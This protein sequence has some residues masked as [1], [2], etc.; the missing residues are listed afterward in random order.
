M[1]NVREIRMDGTTPATEFE[2][3]AST[4]P[5]DAEVTSGGSSPKSSAITV[6]DRYGAAGAAAALAAF[7]AEHPDIVRYENRSRWHLECV[8]P[9]ATPRPGRRFLKNW[10]RDPA[11]E[12]SDGWLSNIAADGNNLM[13][14]LEWEPRYCATPRRHFPCPSCAAGLAERY[15]RYGGFYSCPACEF[16]TN[17]GT[18]KAAAIE[19]AA[20]ITGWCGTLLEVRYNNNGVPYP[21]CKTCDPAYKSPTVNDIYYGRR[22]R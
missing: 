16:K 22:S 5:E 21:G 3:R 11:A 2:V 14:D 7:A 18:K 12:V 17:F 20:T 1:D 8:N 9:A 4:Y 15:S 13:D 6:A 10:E 19:A